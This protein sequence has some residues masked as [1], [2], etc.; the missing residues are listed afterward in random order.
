MTQLVGRFTRSRYED[1]VAELKKKLDA[2]KVYIDRLETQ[3]RAVDA[4]TATIIVD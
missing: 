4:E 1:Q 2:N 3:L